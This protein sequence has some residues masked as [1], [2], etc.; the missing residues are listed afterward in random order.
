MVLEDQLPHKI[1]D[2]L[3]TINRAKVNGWIGVQG[4]GLRVGGLPNQPKEPTEGSGFRVYGGFRQGSGRVH[5]SPE[6]LISKHS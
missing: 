3:F 2:L 5:G 4:S 1:V 6:D